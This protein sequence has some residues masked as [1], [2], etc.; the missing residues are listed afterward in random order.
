MTFSVSKSSTAALP[1]S[2]LSWAAAAKRR[3][4]DDELAGACDAAKQD[5][6]VHSPERGLASDAVPANG[7]RE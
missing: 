1:S 6:D 5:E 3:T 4:R 7:G 2:V